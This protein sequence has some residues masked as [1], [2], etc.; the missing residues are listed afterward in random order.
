MQ[1]KYRGV[2]YS[3]FGFVSLRFID[4]VQTQRQQDFSGI[5]EELVLVHDVTGKKMMAI[6]TICNEMQIGS[7][8]CGRGFMLYWYR[9][10]MG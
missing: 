1:Q 8:T 4:P 6:C 5:L 10:W 2:Q 7:W 3:I 9:R